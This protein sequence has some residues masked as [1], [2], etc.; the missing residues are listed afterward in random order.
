MDKWEI[1]GSLGLASRL[2]QSRD[3]PMV[4]LVSVG[5]YWS[6]AKREGTLRRIC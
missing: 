1:I 5:G 4:G 3:P 6:R 2:T